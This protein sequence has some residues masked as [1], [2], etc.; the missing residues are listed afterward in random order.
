MDVILEL[1]DSYF[2]TP[3]VY[4]ES[5]PEDNM[6]RQF[7]SLS[8]VVT[9][10]AVILYLITASLSYVFVFDR[11]LLSHPLILEVSEYYL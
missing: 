9:V 7:V 2:F 8:V 5:V 6:L 3:F 4:P 1:T 10:T 11:N